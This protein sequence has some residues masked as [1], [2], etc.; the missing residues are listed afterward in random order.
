MLRNSNDLTDVALL[1]F[2]L[3]ADLK[4]KVY[5]FKRCGSPGYLAPEVLAYSEGDKMYGESCDVFSL[6]VVFY[7]VIYGMHPFKAKS[8][9]EALEKNKKSQYDLP[10]SSYYDL[11]YGIE[12]I[13][14][15][16]DNKRNA[17][18][19]SQKKNYNLRINESLIFPLKVRREFLY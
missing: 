16:R 3:C 18:L 19:Q 9:E 7:F 14:R 11:K 13:K 17:E 1:D 15:T 10:K 12:L 8:P 6:G 4:N 2:G 5:G